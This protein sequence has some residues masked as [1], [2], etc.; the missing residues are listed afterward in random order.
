MTLAEK[1]GQLNMPLPV[2]G[3]VPAELD[4]A[5]T[6]PRTHEDFERFARGEH[7]PDLGPGGG[8]F[9]M[10]G[11]HCPEGP[12]RQ[13]EVHNRLQRVALEETRLGIPLLQITEGTH[14]VMTVGATI[15]PEGPTLGSTWD[16]ALLERVYAAIARE[17]RALGFHALCTLV[18]EPTRD[19]RLGRNCEGY[20]EDPWLMSN[21]AEA[22]VRGAQGDDVGAPDKAVA[23]LCHYPVQ[24]EPSS[25]LERGAMEI[26]ERKLREVFLRPWFAGIKRGGALGVMAT[27]AAIDGEPTHGS[28]WL[29]TE[30]LREEL[31]FEGVVLSEGMGFDTLVYEG[32]AATQSAAGELALQAG[33]DLNITY[34]EAYLHPLLENVAAGRIDEKLVD[35]AVRRVLELKSRL[36]L[37]DDPYVDVDR[38][39]EIVH[40]ADHQQL[41]LEAAREGI[42]LLKNKD[43]LLPLSKEVRSIAVIGPNADNPLN[44]LGDYTVGF[45][46]PDAGHAQQVITVL[47][48]VRAKAGATQAV[49]YAKG[50]DVLGDD[51]MGFAEAEAAARSADVAIVVVGEQLGAIAAEGDAFRSTVGE[52]ADVASLDL[53][54][55]Q[56]A[57]I[58]AVHATG[59]PTV[60]VLINGRPLSIRWVAEHVDAIVEAWLP[61]E[62]GGEAVADV[63]F[64]D[65]NPS[66]C[67]PVTVPRH[68]G[69]LPVYYNHRRAKAYWTDRN[70]DYV[71]M[72]ATPLWEF[73]YGL[74]YTSFEYSNLRVDPPAIAPDGEVR[75]SLDV[76]NVGGRAGCEVVQLYVRDVVA[77]LAPA[78]RELRGFEKMGLEPGEQRTVAFVLTPDDLAVLDR[79]LSRVVEPGTFDVLVG[80]SCR[81]IHLEGSFEVKA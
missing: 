59:T 34:E 25:G 72:P 22:I 33:V 65:H 18:V 14:G 56:Q 60:V 1:I 74:S 71:D 11:I 68:V 7:D 63:L 79:D 78:D 28:R 8:F 17:A 23:V 35:R 46:V 55:A 76:R 26:S 53:T 45:L 73:G 29:L 52:R 5:A 44:Q 30:V 77:S 80:S 81:R 51:T 31:G 24:S 58:A 61:G 66:G 3:L 57:L 10:A 32:V 50:C 27:Y 67:L 41:C 15:F 75:V 21:Y 40:S 39:E 9:G 13:A 49:H 48:G 2:A 4:V 36:G 38:A 6:M 62:R 42:V 43:G 47:D 64:G 54:G 37:F 19:P 12:R 20:T 16:P 70:Y 69:Q